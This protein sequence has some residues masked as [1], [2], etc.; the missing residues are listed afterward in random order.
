MTVLLGYFLWIEL[1][2][3]S[4][5]KTMKLLAEF[6]TGTGTYGLIY[7]G[8]MAAHQWKQEQKLKDLG[9]MYEAASAY[10]EEFR[11]VME[12]A[13]HCLT[14][15][16][17]YEETKLEDRVQVTDVLPD[18]TRLNNDLIRTYW[19]LE[20]R[21][22]KDVKDYIWNM[23]E[24]GMQY[25]SLILSRSRIRKGLTEK[26]ASI[27]KAMQDVLEFRN[28]LRGLFKKHLTM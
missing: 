15:A 22:P 19:R 12:R 17:T 4:S 6:L 1:Y 3:I 21:L 26:E 7:V 27:V 28:K 14:W 13:Q 24:A 25:E 16:A 9:E 18:L 8:W 10:T 5:Y 11:D 20:F 2:H 23:R